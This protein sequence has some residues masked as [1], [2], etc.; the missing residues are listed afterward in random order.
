MLFTFVM[1]YLK[2]KL[3]WLVIISLVKLTEKAL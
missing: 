2:F 1:Y 3:E